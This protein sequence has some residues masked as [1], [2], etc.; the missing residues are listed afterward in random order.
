MREAAY[1]PPG[2]KALVTQ[3]NY[4]DGSNET[5]RY[6]SFGQVTSHRLPSGAT[7]TKEYD[8]R[9]LL[10][11]EYNDVDGSAARKEYTYAVPTGTPN[12][13]W[14]RVQTMQDGRARAAGAA[15][16]A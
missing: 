10:L 6:N 3:I 12:V 2:L 8:G 5:F 7:E 14:D 4:P 16:S 1:Q 9:G 13:N 11:R 15:Y